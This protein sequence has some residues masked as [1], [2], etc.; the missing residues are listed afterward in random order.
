MKKMIPILSMLLILSGCPN[1]EHFVDTNDENSRAV[2]NSVNGFSFETYSEMFDDYSSNSV[3]SPLSLYYCLA[4]LYEGATGDA[5]TELQNLMNLEE[6]T[7]ICTTLGGL[8]KYYKSVSYNQ[9]LEIALAN[10]IWLKEGCNFKE[11]WES[12][13]RSKLDSEVAQV[14]SFNDSTL[15]SI[16][17][18]GKRNTKGLIEKIL[19]SVDKGT[20]AVLANA[21]YFNGKW[22]S[23]FDKSKTEKR[24]FH[25]SADKTVQ[26]NTMYIKEEFS[27]FENESF[28]MIKLP[29]KTLKFSLYILLPNEALTLQKMEESLTAATFIKAQKNS[30]TQETMLYLPK[31]KIKSEHKDIVQ[32][33]ETLGVTKIFQPGALKNISETIVTDEITQKACIEIDESG[34]EAAA[35]TVVSLKN[36]ASQIYEV[37]VDRPFS[38]ILFDEECEQVLFRGRIIDPTAE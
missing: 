6:G 30:K 12:S 34:T 26:A 37:N 19:S 15:N 9:G 36:A 25:I 32:Q 7:D 13:M 22:E 3:F 10:G 5:K 33:F 14:E 21:I 29:Y 16:N 23:K 8:K 1:I 28:S 38:F 17:A 20:Q 31:F 24:D 35:V 27:T 2:I 18:W 11:T 4:M